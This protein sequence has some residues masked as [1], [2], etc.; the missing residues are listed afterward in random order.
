MKLKM[1]KKSDDIKKFLELS[2]GIV[3]AGSG[4]AVGLL[5]GGPSGAIT[6]STVGVLL[7]KGVEEFCN[8]V[9]SHREAVRVSAV[10]AMAINNIHERLQSGVKVRDDG[11]LDDDNGGRSSAEELFEGVLL[12]GKN[13]HRE[14]KLKLYS[15]V[16]ANAFFYEGISLEEIY[17]VLKLAEELTYDSFCVLSLFCRP[18]LFNRHNIP[19]RINLSDCGD[20]KRFLLFEILHLMNQNLLEIGPIESPNS[21]WAMNLGVENVVPRGLRL[22]SFMNR[23]YKILGL[24]EIPEK[25]IEPILILMR[26]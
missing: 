21:R 10:A 12:K 4:T 3:G 19:E 15:N 16:F 13:E 9:L 1:D 11:F 5:I 18:E 22:T 2:S 26:E 20:P 7:T 17:F 23:H 14:K 8:R 6:G 24:E 25:D